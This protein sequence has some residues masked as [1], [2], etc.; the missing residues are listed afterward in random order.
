MTMGEHARLARIAAGLT[1]TKLAGDAGLRESNIYNIETDKRS[2]SL[3]QLVSITSVLRIG[4]DEYLGL[5]PRRPFW[6]E[7][8][9]RTTSPGEWA[10]YLRAEKHFLSL[11]ELSD[12]SGVNTQTITHFEK[13]RTVPRLNVLLELANAM[14]MSLDEYIGNPYPGSRKH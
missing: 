13:G 9:R 4:M 2:P 1:V 12:R 8:N 3:V 7:R 11:R 6:E 5:P 10:R 14:D